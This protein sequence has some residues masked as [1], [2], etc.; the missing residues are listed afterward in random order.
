MVMAMLNA[1]YLL[2]QDTIFED[3]FIVQTF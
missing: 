2:Q 3:G 1:T